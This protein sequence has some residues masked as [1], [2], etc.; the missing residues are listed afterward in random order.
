MQEKSKGLLMN[1]ELKSSD[2]Q[3]I[4]FNWYYNILKLG[5]AENDGINRASD[6]IESDSRFIITLS[7]L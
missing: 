5:I 4:E 3:K 1:S 6:S 2:R 7:Q